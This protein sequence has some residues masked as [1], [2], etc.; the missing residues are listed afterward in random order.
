MNGHNDTQKGNERIKEIVNLAPERLRGEWVEFIKS[1][2]GTGNKDRVLAAIN[3][4]R[5]PPEEAEAV[6]RSWFTETQSFDASYVFSAVNYFSGSLEFDKYVLLR[7]SSSP[8]DTASEPAD[9]EHRRDYLVNTSTDELIKRNYLIHKAVEGSQGAME[10]WKVLEEKH[11]P[12]ERKKNILG[13]VF[14]HLNESGFE[15]LPSLLKPDM[16]KLWMMLE[17]ANVP[18]SVKYLVIKFISYDI[19]TTSFFR[20]QC[21]PKEEW[22][23]HYGGT[24]ASAQFAALG[25]AISAVPFDAPVG[26]NR[27]AMWNA[28]RKE[29]TI[30]AQSVAQ[31]ASRST[32]MDF[33]HQLAC[34]ATE[35]AVYD[36]MSEAEDDAIAEVSLR[37]DANTNPYA[38]EASDAAILDAVND[39]SECAALMCKFTLIGDL[40]S[41][42]DRHL[43]YAKELWNEAVRNGFTPCCDLEDQLYVFAKAPAAL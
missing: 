28:K 3:A 10:L 41:A 42:D 36:V 38:Y 9:A 11:V 23:T 18:D 20:P 32:V 13:F 34:N 43:S 19:P 35:E 4:M 7:G 37:A 14:D 29:A 2:I 40:V 1:E 33:V 25:A 30:V 16:L 24:L 17:T 8:N 39:V 31:A 22:I 15:L 26:A 21:A 6:I 5:N 12:N 27:N